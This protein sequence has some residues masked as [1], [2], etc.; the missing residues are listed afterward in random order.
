MKLKN[1][2]SVS[3]RQ[4]AYQ[5]RRILND[6]LTHEEV[7]TTWKAIFPDIAI[8]S[9]PEIQEWLSNCLLDTSQSPRDR[10]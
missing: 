2:K 5:L 3:D 9:I 6:E 7:T 4:D 8:W 10:G 1:Y